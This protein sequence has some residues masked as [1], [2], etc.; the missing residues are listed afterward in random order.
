MYVVAGV[1]GQTGRA[2]AESLL[3]DGRPVRV[4]VRER[5]KGEE[6]RRRGADV[7]VASL[8]DADS[9]SRALAG[10]DG[11]YLLV[12]PVYHVPDVL[13]AQRPRVEAIAAAIRSS[14][15][16]HAVLL[17][18]VAAHLPN[19]TG[20]IRIL[21]AAERAVRPAAKN[22]TILRPAYFLENWVPV[23]G[24]AREKGVLPTFLTP[25]RP[26]ATIG[27]RDVGRAAARALKEPATGTRV[28]E[29]AGPKDQTP[30]D[31]ARAVGECLGREIRV[32]GLPIEA[33]A[34]AMTSFGMSENA[35]ALYQEM[36][37]GVN[38]GV[39][40]AEGERTPGWQGTLTPIDVLGP[41]LDAGGREGV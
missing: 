1:S 9:L 33:A 37:A 11:A 26:I 28:I 38:A 29:L 20:L 7:A 16:P 3:E 6:W 14:G 22:L 10:A 32:L 13:A 23:L 41:I 27:T 15:L 36:I 24:E 17:S 35:A 2:A 4:L 39:V 8:D 12:P 31:V 25:G 18:S 34:P 40:E 5:E 21:H 19:G 30:E